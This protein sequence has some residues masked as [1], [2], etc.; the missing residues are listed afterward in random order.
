MEQ[1]YLMDTN[2]IIDNLGNKL[3]ENAK[4]FLYA[5]DFIVS[6]ITKIEVLGWRNATVE[7]LVPLNDLLN[8]A[9]IIPI[10]E[11]V[12]DRTIKIRQTNKIDLGDAIIAG[13]ALAFDFILVTRNVSDFKNIDRLQVINPYQL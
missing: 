8:A 6:A 5:L 4:E 9:T 11:S 3:P 13:T 10:S 2:V 12:I 1:R 7:Q